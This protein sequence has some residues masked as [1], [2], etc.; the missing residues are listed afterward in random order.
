MHSRGRTG[1]QRAA[2][3]EH[4]L[5][6]QRPRCALQAVI[7]AVGPGLLPQ[8]FAAGAIEPAAA[9]LQL[10]TDGPEGHG[11]LLG[12]LR[13]PPDVAGHQQHRRPDLRTRRGKLS[14]DEAA[15]AV[16]HGVNTRLV[17][18]IALALQNEIQHRVSVLQI[19]GQRVIA[20]AAPAAAVMEGHHMEAS[21]T[22]NLGQVE[23]PLTAGDAVKQQYGGMGSLPRRRIEHRKQPSPLSRNKYAVHTRS[24]GAVSVMDLLIRRSVR[25]R[26]ASL[27]F[28]VYHI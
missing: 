9:L 7:V 4:R 5:V 12:D 1:I 28:S 27:S 11:I 17:Y 14:A 13:H 2:D 16:A 10:L 18:A 26:P 20:V 15:Q 24:V 23:V 3:A 21:A 22:Q 19:V 6:R 8:G 25:H